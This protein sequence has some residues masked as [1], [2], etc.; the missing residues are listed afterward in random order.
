MRVGL[1]VFE[2]LPGLELLPE[3]MLLFMLPVMFPALF[4]ALLPV[5]PAL[6][7]VSPAL[8]PVFPALP[9]SALFCLGLA[10]DTSSLLN[11]YS[12]GL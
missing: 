6:F 8:L 5:F 7:P 4:P 2:L 3:T 1:T 12:G 10:N 11:L 9:V